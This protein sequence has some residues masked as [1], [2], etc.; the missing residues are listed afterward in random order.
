MAT[1]TLQVIDGLEMGQIFGELP[2]PVTI[3]REEENQIRLNDD[4]V[5]RFH[6][7]IQED[8]GRIILTDLESTNGTRVNGH[9]VKMRIL[10]IGDQISIGRCLLVYGSRL[11]L[12]Q[13]AGLVPSSGEKKADNEDDEGTSL[14]SPSTGNLDAFPEGAP[15]IPSGLSPLQAAQLSDAFAYV[16]GQLLDILQRG[17]EQ[18]LYSTKQ[19]R[20]TMAVPPAAWHQLQQLEL[21]LSTWLRN[22]AEPDHKG[23]S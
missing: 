1:V 9:P 11:E 20:A 16:R 19:N 3:G 12:A 17:E 22:V 23:S 5:S 15:D 6:A 7:K 10:R 13:K 8:E 2:T 4:R 21:D 14:P 18:H